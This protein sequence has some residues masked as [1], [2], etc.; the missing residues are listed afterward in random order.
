MGAER[1]ELQVLRG[2]G[3][4]AD[5]IRLYDGDESGAGIRQWMA[6]TKDVPGI[7]GSMY[8]TW[9]DKYDAM[10]PWAKQAWGK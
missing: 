10:G 7:V 4:E 8:T 2:F 5:S 9:E 3:A 6:N 1:E